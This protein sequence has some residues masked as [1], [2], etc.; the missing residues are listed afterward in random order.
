MCQ[1]QSGMRPSTQAGVYERRRGQ[2][3]QVQCSERSRPGPS[4]QLLRRC[5]DANLRRST[6]RI[7]CAIFSSLSL[8]GRSTSQRPSVLCSSRACDRATNSSH[9]IRLLRSYK[10]RETI[11]HR[12]YRPPAQR[13]DYSPSFSAPPSSHRTGVSLDTLPPIVRVVA[14]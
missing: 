2:R 3:T 5:L 1:V 13:V 10:K 8:R 9:L 7:S 12:K 14:P 11:D 6:S 4:L